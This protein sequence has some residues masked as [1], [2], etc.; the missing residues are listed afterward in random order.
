MSVEAQLH[1]GVRYLDVRI[2]A[3]WN[4]THTS[5][6]LYT[7]HRFA[8]QPLASVIAGICAF[9]DVAVGEFVIIDL[10]ADHT[11]KGSMDRAHMSETARVHMAHTFMVTLAPLLS[12]CHSTTA[13]KWPSYA[14]VL[15]GSKGQRR[16]LLLVQPGVLSSW[17]AIGPGGRNVQLVVPYT[18]RVKHWSDVITPCDNNTSI[19]LTIARHV[20][21]QSPSRALYV[22]EET[23]TPSKAMVVAAVMC[24]LNHVTVTT[25]GWVL[26][27]SLGVYLLW[28]KMGRLSPRLLVGIIATSLVSLVIVAL[29][30][31]ARQCDNT[32]TSILTASKAVR[33]TLTSLLHTDPHLLRYVSVVSADH[34]SDSFAETVIAL[35]V[36]KHGRVLV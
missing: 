15:R 14:E 7:Y 27:V 26:F 17:L 25:M 16:I 21:N 9:V 20:S 13:A 33:G 6:V 3:H 30:W 24:D 5:T 1:S 34:V 4:A 2:G 29:V 28:R 31:F 8:L 32:H 23:L 36:K 22:W 10:T 18:L 35:N 19:L 11:N 12:R